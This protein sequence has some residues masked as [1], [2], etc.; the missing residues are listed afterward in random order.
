MNKSYLNKIT[1]GFVGFVGLVFFLLF[2]STVVQ[3]VKASPDTS[4]LHAVITSTPT[5]T[6]PVPQISLSYHKPTTASADP[7]TPNQ[8]PEKAVDGIWAP[9]WPI[10]C[11]TAATKWMQIDLGQNYYI[12]YVD[13]HHSQLPYTTKDFSIYGIKDTGSKWTQLQTIVAVTN[14]TTQETPFNFVVGSN[15]TIARWLRVTVKTGAQTGQ[16]N[17]ARI[18]DV[19]V[20]GVPAP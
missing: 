8:G 11:T 15:A 14:N 7:C 3:V 1:I 20:D 6:P 18:Y 19:I 2:M 17:I 10:W 13:I 5:S 16:T 9:A 4:A 12:T